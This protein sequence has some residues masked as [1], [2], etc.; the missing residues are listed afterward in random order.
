MK[1][2]KSRST[3][4]LDWLRAVR[5]KIQKEIGA[6]PKERGAYYRA[7]EKKLRSR[8]YP[9]RSSADTVK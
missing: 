7:R 2:R 1:T 5:H 6:T 3:D 4:G 8:I 9:G